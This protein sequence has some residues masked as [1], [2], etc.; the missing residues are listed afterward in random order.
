MSDWRR[1][2]L[3]SF[4]LQR[5]AIFVQD[6]YFNPKTLGGVS[7]PYISRELSARNFVTLPT[8]KCTIRPTL[9]DFQLGNLQL[10]SLGMTIFGEWAWLNN[11]KLDI[12]VHN[13]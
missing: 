1:E 3:Y 13:F 12:N 10:G 9:K 4:L 6:N 7:T 5:I 11:Q 8:I 2:I